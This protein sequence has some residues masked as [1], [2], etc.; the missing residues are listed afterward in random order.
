MRQRILTETKRLRQTPFV[1]NV[2][3]VASG[4]IASQIIALAFSPIIAMLYGPGV[5]GMLGVF[6][7]I[8][9]ILVPVAAMTYAMAVVLPARDEDAWDLVELSL[10][11]AFL[12]SICIGACFC[13]RAP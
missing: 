11:L 5:F 13:H 10:G 2:A 8:V 1:R 6:S 7:T 12:T 3:T 4:S 9:A